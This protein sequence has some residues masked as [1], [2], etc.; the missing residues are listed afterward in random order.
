[1]SPTR[2]FASEEVAMIELDSKIRKY[3][4]WAFNTCFVLGYG[5]LP[6]SESSKPFFQAN[7]Q[8]KLCMI[9]LALAFIVLTWLRT[10]KLSSIR[11]WILSIACLTGMFFLGASYFGISVVL[12]LLGFL[13]YNSFIAIREFAANSVNS[14]R[15]IRNESAKH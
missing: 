6:R 12:Y 2:R 5:F 11:F 13:I 1:L 15:Q 9:L 7:W 3:V 4:N 10:K 14:Y 8:A